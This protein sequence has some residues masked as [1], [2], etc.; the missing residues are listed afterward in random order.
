M[1]AKLEA[2]ISSM[3]SKVNELLKLW[4]LPGVSVTLVRDG[5]TIFSDAYGSRDIA[6]DLPMTTKYVTEQLRSMGLEPEEI[7][8]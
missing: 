8:P 1:S 3:D 7:C 2:I 5:K 4:N 6:A